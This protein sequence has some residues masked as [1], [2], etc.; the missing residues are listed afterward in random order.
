MLRRLSFV[1]EV[2]ASNREGVRYVIK[3][4]FLER[5]RNLF[6]LTSRWLYQFV[7]LPSSSYISIEGIFPLIG[8]MPVVIYL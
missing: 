8:Y 3:H 7:L 1:I 4:V 2:H 5:R 6:F